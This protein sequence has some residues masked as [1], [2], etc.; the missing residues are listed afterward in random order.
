MKYNK[1]KWTKILERDQRSWYQVVRKKTQ[2]STQLLYWQQEY[3][4]TYFKK[5]KSKCLFPGSHCFYQCVISSHATSVK[6][7]PTEMLAWLPKLRVELSMTAFI[8]ALVNSIG[9]EWFIPECEVFTESHT[10]CYNKNICILE[11]K[12]WSFVFEINEISKEVPST[13]FQTYIVKTS[14]KCD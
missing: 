14:L 2:L 1:I 3:F 9:F 5:I 11:Q 10:L 6:S 8:S 13:F 12:C 4:Q 7:P